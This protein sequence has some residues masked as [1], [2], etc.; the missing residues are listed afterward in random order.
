MGE[1]LTFANVRLAVEGIA[2]YA[3]KE[4]P[5]LGEQLKELCNQVGS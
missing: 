4:K 3:A 2:R 1:E 5:A